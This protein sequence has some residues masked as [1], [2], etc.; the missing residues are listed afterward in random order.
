MTVRIVLRN[1]F[2]RGVR[3][4]AWITPFTVSPVRETTQKRIDTNSDSRL[5]RETGEPTAK[6]PQIRV[7]FPPMNARMFLIGNK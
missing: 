6:N 1:G 3:Y 7:K 2:F 4:L 5:G